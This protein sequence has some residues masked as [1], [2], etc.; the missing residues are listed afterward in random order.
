MLLTC[1]HGAFH[2]IRGPSHLWVALPGPQLETSIRG[3]SCLRADALRTV[4][5]E[6]HG[7]QVAGVHPGECILT[8]ARGII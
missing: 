1:D 8:L 4:W 6:M 7:T 2:V 3:R 5:G